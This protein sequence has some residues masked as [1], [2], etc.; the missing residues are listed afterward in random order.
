MVHVVHLPPPHGRGA[1]VREQARPGLQVRPV[2]GGQQEQQA[3]DREPAHRDQQSRGAPP[4][5]G[6]PCG[7][8]KFHMLT[9]LW[10]A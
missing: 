4:A 8:K 5:A 6:R 7:I 1:L 3:R 9:R 10:S 2:R